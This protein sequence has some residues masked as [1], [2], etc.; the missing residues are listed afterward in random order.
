VTRSPLVKLAV[1][2]HLAGKQVPRTVEGD[3][4]WDPLEELIAAYNSDRRFV[5]L[6]SEVIAHLDVDGASSS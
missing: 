2:Q 5:E 4:Q 6:A 1:S 3:V